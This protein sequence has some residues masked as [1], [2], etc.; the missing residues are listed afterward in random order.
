M[1]AISSTT[2]NSEHQWLLQHNNLSSNATTTK[3]NNSNIKKGNKPP[4]FLFLSD[5]YTGNDDDDNTDT[6][7]NVGNRDDDSYD[8]E[9]HLTR[10]DDEYQHGERI[11]GQPSAVVV[12][13]NNDNKDSQQFTKEEVLNDNVNNHNNI[14]SSKDNDN[15]ND[16]SWEDTSRPRPKVVWLMSYPNSGTSYTMMM[17]ARASNQAT[18]SNYGKEV[19]VPPTPN[20]PIYPGQ[21][22]GPFYRPNP[23]HPLPKDYILVKTHCGGMYT[24]VGYECVWVCVG[25]SCSI[26]GCARA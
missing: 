5:R 14:T 13:K 18:A 15:N 8:D 23:Q 9:E 16:F 22:E 11:R 20:R 2:T 1:D 25:V 6:G 7:V 19:T 17:V 21:W 4:P 26:A 12:N 24:Y 3:N 10:D